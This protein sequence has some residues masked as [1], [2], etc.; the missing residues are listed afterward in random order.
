LGT[1][2]HGRS[3]MCVKRGVYVGVVGVGSAHGRGAGLGHRSHMEISREGTWYAREVTDQSCIPIRQRATARTATGWVGL[4]RESW[5]L[6][7][8]SVITVYAEYARARARASARV[9]MAW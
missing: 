6:A 2:S 9:T 4:L 1:C 3:W 5:S 7:S 8:A